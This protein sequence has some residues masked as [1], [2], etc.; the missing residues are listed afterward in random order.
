MKCL[1]ILQSYAHL[2]CCLAAADPRRKRVENR[3][4]DLFRNF[5][6]LLLIHAGKGRQLLWP[7]RPDAVDRHNH[8]TNNYGI[9]HTDLTFGAILGAVNV[10]SHFELGHMR[11][12]IGSFEMEVNGAVTKSES[13]NVVKKIIPAA[14]L[15]ARPWL[16]THQHVEGPHCMVFENIRRFQEPIPCKGAQGI[17]NLPKSLESQVKSALSSAERLP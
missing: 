2:I 8:Y 4:H 11:A 14:E 1:T 3:Q 7:Y 9:P 16:A 13:Q 12:F 15:E 6:G 10:V 17:W 5:R